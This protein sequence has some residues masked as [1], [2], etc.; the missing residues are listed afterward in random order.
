MQQITVTKADFVQVGEEVWLAFRP[1][2]VNAAADLCDELTEGKEYILTVKR[3]GRSL[4]AN[5]YFWTLVNRLADKLQ[6]DP[7]GIYRAYL[8][9]IG[10]NYEIIPVKEDRIEAWEKVWCDGHIGR[11][12]EDMG[13]CRTVKGYHNVRTYFASSD[14]DSRQMARLIEL[15]VADCKENGIET[16]TPRE[17]EALVS[18]WGEVTA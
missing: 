18:R 3:K 1:K 14:F 13:P 17:L 8:P 2:S 10:G 6:I 5:A 9:D 12:I 11:M 16:M 15:V 4:D 7:N